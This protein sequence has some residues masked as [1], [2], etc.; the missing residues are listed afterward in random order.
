MRL[1]INKTSNGYFLKV[2]KFLTVDVIER[3]F[4][5]RYMDEI[6]LD[7]IITVTYLETEDSFF[8]Y[9]ISVNLLNF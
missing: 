1:E 5:E 8:Y 3:L 4:I 2:N 7:D 9:F 6:K